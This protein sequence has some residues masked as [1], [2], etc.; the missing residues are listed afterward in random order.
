MNSAMFLFITG[1]LLTLGGVGG[2]EQSIT[3]M[4]LVQGLIISAVGLAV[5]YCGTM[6]MKI[7]QLTD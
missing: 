6:M 4:E 5:M 3:D 2:I 1:L 7:S